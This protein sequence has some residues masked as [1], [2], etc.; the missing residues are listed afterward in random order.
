M[1]A[2][3]VDGSSNHTLIRE[4]YP[5]FFGLLPVTFADNACFTCHEAAS[6]QERLDDDFADRNGTIY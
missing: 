6:F 4:E 1:A 3:Y 2:G 5:L